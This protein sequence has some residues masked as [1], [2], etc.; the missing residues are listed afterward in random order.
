MENSS[1]NESKNKTADLAKYQ[2]EYMHKR[3]HD[4]VEKSRLYKNSL[5]AKKVY[6]MT[7]EDL[8]TYG[9]YLADFCKLKLI[10]ERMPQDLFEQSLFNLSL[11]E[12]TQTLND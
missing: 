7:A 2:R 12:H 6:N 4:N 11:D 3:Y 5:K 9:E 8:K 10:K 1:T